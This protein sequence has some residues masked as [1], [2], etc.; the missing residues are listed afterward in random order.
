MQLMQSPRM[1][2]VRPRSNKV[3][4]LPPVVLDFTKK[5]NSVRILSGCLNTQLQPLLPMGPPVRPHSIMRTAQSNWAPHEL[6]VFCFLL[7]GE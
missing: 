7:T 2:C 5:S 6:E 4:A 1:G 3:G